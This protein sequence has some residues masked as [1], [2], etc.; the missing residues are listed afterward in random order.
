MIHESSSQHMGQPYAS[1]ATTGAE[2]NL[3]S[4]PTVMKED[5]VDEVEANTIDEED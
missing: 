2:E 5:S 1:E 4:A 3:Y